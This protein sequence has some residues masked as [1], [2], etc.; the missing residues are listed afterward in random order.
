MRESAPLTAL[1]LLGGSFSP[2][3]N[4]HL[5]G[6]IEALTLLGIEQLA[7]I[8]APEPP[9]KELPSVSIAHRVAMLRLAIKDLPGL[10]LDIRELDRNG[11]NYTVDTLMELRAQYGP[12]ISL[13]FIM[14]ADSLENLPRWSR[15]EQLLEFANIAVLTRPGVAVTCSEPV[16]GWLKEHRCG[17]KMLRGQAAGGIALL[18]QTSLDISSTAIRADIHT[19]RSVRFLLPD[20]VIEYIAQH[21]LYRE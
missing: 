9:L 19:G 10:S 21:D 13:I 16:A 3:H 15:W 4:G 14:G 5:R 8:P 1:G 18:R 20:A 6:A 12:D 11:P 2:V 17:A 7:L